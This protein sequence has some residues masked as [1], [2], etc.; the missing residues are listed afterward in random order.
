MFFVLIVNKEIRI[1]IISLITNELQKWKIYNSITILYSLTESQFK[2]ALCLVHMK[3]NPFIDIFK[4]QRCYCVLIESI[5]RLVEQCFILLWASC[6]SLEPA[7]FYITTLL[8]GIL[9]LEE[10]ASLGW[11]GLDRG[12]LSGSARLAPILLASARFKPGL[13]QGCDARWQFALVFH[14]S[15]LAAAV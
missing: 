6:R 11:R 1:Q 15:L 12:K 2:K 8:H 13:C 9:S 4:W 10:V 3:V 14:R 5:V 7:W